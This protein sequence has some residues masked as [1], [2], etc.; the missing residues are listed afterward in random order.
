MPAA[1]QERFDELAKGLATNR[2][3][4]RQVLKSFVAG[5]LLATPL[6][7]LWERKALAQTVE[8]VRSRCVA[9][10]EREYDECKKGCRNLPTRRRRRRCLTRCRTA[11]GTQ[12]LDCGCVTLN[13]NTATGGVTPAPCEDPCTAQVLHDQASQDVHY[14]LLADYLANDGFAPDERPNAIVFKEDG[15]LVRSEL[16]STYSHPTRTNEL[17]TLYYHVEST[18][19]TLAFAAVWDNQEKKLLY[20]LISDGTGLVQRVEPSTPSQ[21]TNMPSTVSINAAGKTCGSERLRLCLLGAGAALTAC[22]VKDCLIP[23]PKPPLVPLCIPPNT[24]ACA[25]CLAKCAA[26]TAIV[27]TG[28]S[29]LFGCGVLNTKFCSNDVCCGITETGCSGNCC[30]SLEECCSGICCPSCQTCIDGACSPK[31]TTPP[32]TNCVDGTCMC[33]EG[34]EDPCGNI[35]CPAG[36]KCCGGTTCCDANEEC[37]GT[38]CCGSETCD[39]TDPNSCGECQECAEVPDPT[40]GFTHRCI[41][42]SGGKVCCNGVCVNP[43]PNGLLRDPITCECTC[44]APCST[45]K[46]GQCVACELADPC[47]FCFFDA[48]TREGECRPKCGPRCTCVTENDGHTFVNCECLPPI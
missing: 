41:G 13:T 31:C 6:G 19:E 43:C 42:C 33:P 35:C 46:D 22:L 10:A 36:Q 40:A 5:V 8:C 11:F 20:L 21:Q 48:V 7:A 39:P 23:G 27:A 34:T 16:S 14:S 9:R 24:P 44:D 1:I 25:I 30:A 28:C 26:S 3:S 45:Y 12:L 32:L 17:A 4:R 47:T 15:T 2:L 37:C 29:L 18:S 38:T